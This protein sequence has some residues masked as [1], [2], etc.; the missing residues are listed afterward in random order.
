[1]QAVNRFVPEY[2]WDKPDEGSIW[3]ER[4]FEPYGV[5][6]HAI[7]ASEGYDVDQAVVLKKGNRRAFT[8]LFANGCSCWNGD[9]EGWTNLSKAELKKLADTWA[10]PTP[11]DYQYKYAEAEIG[12]WLKE[13][14][15][16]I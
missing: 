6:V 8:V 16:S 2:A 13:N 3:D 11:E 7:D 12:R 15:S 4:E 5:V 9:Y 1:M 14:W 10:K